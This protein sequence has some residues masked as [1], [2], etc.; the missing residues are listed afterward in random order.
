MVSAHCGGKGASIGLWA[1]YRKR[2]IYDDGDDDDDED[3]DADAHDDDVDDY[4]DGDDNDGKGKYW[5]AKRII[6]KGISIHRAAVG[7]G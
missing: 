1:D 6:G 4:D 2:N 3:Y 7:G 5:A